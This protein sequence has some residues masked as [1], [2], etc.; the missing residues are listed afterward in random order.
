MQ[1]IRMQITNRGDVLRGIGCKRMRN[2]RGTAEKNW[3]GCGDD[4]AMVKG[5][6][7][8]MDGEGETYTDHSA[9][10]L[11]TRK[12]SLTD[13]NARPSLFTFSSSMN[14]RFPPSS[15]SLLSFFSTWFTFHFVSRLDVSPFREFRIFFF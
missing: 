4:K 8:W 14:R 6:G 10:C 9:P 13:S 7:T 5:N 12:S 11:P 15:L 3:R 1:R 2:V